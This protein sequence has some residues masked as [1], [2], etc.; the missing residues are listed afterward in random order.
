M[1]LSIEIPTASWRI[2]LP[3]FPML[4]LWLG[5]QRCVSANLGDWLMDDLDEVRFPSPPRRS[6]SGAEGSSISLS[7]LLSRHHHLFRFVIFLAFF[8]QS[9]QDFSFLVMPT[10][11]LVQLQFTTSVLPAVTES[12]AA[13]PFLRLNSSH[14]GYRGL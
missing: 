3:Q 10:C 8:F 9:V 13:R 5:G 2:A 6:T 14:L 4:G 1:S 12:L 11:H 7:H